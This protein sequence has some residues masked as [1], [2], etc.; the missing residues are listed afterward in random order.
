MLDRAGLESARTVVELGPGTGAITAPLLQRVSSKTLVF[1]LEV[2][3]GHVRSLRARFPTLQV[4][5]DSAENLRRHLSRFR[6]RRAD[7]IVSALPWTNMPS[8]LQ[9]RILDSILDSIAPNG[10]LVTFTYAPVRWL[11]GARRFHRLLNR[12]F[13]DVQISRV[14]WRNVPPA[15][16]YCC[17]RPWRSAQLTPD[18]PI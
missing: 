5:M 16:I 10:T 4:F 13:S 15:V 14:V 18:G 11:P 2:N 1:A 12:H 7:T 3:E 9:Q 17:R 8:D 6:V